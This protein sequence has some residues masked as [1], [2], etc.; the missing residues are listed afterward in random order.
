M[1]DRVGVLAQVVLV[2]TLRVALS[3]QS[4]DLLPQHRPHWLRHVAIIID[5]EQGKKKVF[6]S[7]C[8]EHWSDLCAVLTSLK[9]AN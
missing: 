7:Y 3:K 9:E 1:W 8:S 6:I 2:E 4:D 5:W